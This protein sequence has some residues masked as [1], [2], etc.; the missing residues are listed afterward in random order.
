MGQLIKVTSVPFQAIHFTQNARLVPAD[1]IDIER[2][3][4]MARHFAFNSRYCGGGGGIDLDYVNQV[5]KAFSLAQSSSQPKMPLPGQNIRPSAGQGSQAAGHLAL[6]HSV[7]AKHIPSPA[8]VS[9]NIQSSSDGTWIVTPVHEAVIPEP[10]AAY[11]LQRGSFELRV[12]KGELSYIPP[13][14]MTII[15]Q[16]PEIH[17]EYTGGYHYFPSPD[18][19]F[20]GNVNLSI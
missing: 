6:E 12:A 1:H 10:Q 20:S 5:N 4:A 19:S 9:N 17:F 18:H 7:P 14:D 3:K 11:T 8:S 2:R 15:T 16:Y 13:L